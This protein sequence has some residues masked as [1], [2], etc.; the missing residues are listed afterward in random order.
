MSSQPKSLREAQA[1][2]VVPKARTRRKQQV[3]HAEI[4]RMAEAEAASRAAER[5]EMI[6]IAAYLR[7]E[8]RG[9]EPGHELE[10]WYAAEMEVAEAQ[11]RS[12]A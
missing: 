3:D 4:V 10:D 7:A 5:R 9:F 1:G 12:F 11:Q 2:T 6:A 8:K